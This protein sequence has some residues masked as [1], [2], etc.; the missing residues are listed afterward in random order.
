[1]AA[2]TDAIP[3]LVAGRS[4]DGGGAA[5]TAIMTTDTVAKQSVSR[6]GAAIVGGMAKGAA[7][8]RPDMATMLAVLTTDAEIDAETL[9]SLL[10][11]AVDVSFNRLTTD[12]AQSTNDT[13]ICLASGKAGPVSETDLQAALT[14]VCTDLANQMAAD[15][16]G[17]T[18]VVRVRVVGA[19][20]DADAQK[21]ARQVGQSELVKC[22][23]YGEDPYW[24]RV[25][26]ELG[27]AGI[28]F[29]PDRLAISY[30]DH[31][32]CSGGV[33]APH[34]AEKVAA[35]MSQK[36]LEITADLGLGAGE[37]WVVSVDLTHGYIDENMG[38]S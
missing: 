14:D 7:M 13:V 5:A 3:A 4:T 8:L 2:I 1:M 28:E 29:D 18:K 32:V 21:G 37:G 26:S 31:Q 38:T 22:S 10:A 27:C 6:A 19:A 17:S 20:S 11:A 16:E 9:R 35:Y 30:G 36:F 24:G 15:A 33:D 12:G 23:W 34:D 25:A